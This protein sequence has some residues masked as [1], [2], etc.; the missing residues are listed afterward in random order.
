MPQSAAGSEDGAVDFQLS[1]VFP[2]SRSPVA[3][4]A[5]FERH[6]P[7][8]PVSCRPELAGFPVIPAVCIKRALG[9]LGLCL[10]LWARA[11]FQAC[12]FAVW[13][14]PE[15]S[16]RVQKG[17]GGDFQSREGSEVYR[18][19]VTLLLPFKG[20][21]PEDPGIV[22]VVAC[23]VGRTAWGASAQN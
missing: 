2:V 18:V 1:S 21:C 3:G 13:G 8:N 23:S 12:K 22:L 15:E 10:P 6:V 17:E 19:V 20:S 4:Q 16:R 5:G 9:S 14:I 7:L 11:V